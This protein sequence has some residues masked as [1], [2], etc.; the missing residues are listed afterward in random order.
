MSSRVVQQGRRAAK[1]K[2]RVRHPTARREPDGR[3]PR[4]PTGRRTTLFLVLFLAVAALSAIGV[5]MVLSA[6]AAASLSD[7]DD[8]WSLFRGQLIWVGV[9]AVALLVTMRIDYHRWRILAVPTL[10]LSLVLLVL[11]TVPGV[12]VTANGAS[13]WLGVGPFV[14]Q[15]SELAKLALV[16]F[17]ADLLARPTRPIDETGITLR[18][19]IAVTALLVLLLMLQPH[20]G[21]S[22]IIGVI[23]VAMLFLAG[24]PMLPLSGFA[25]AGSSLAAAVVLTSPWR[26]ARWLAFLDPW[27]DPLGHGYQPLQSLHAVTVGGLAGVG[28]GSS[29]AKWGFLPYAHTDFIF[30]VIAE[31]LGLFGAIAVVGLFATIGVAGFLTSLRA[32]DRFGML[33]AFGITTWILAQAV[34]NM[35]AVLALVPVLGVTLPFLSFGGSSLVV[36]M[37][38]F[39]L[40]LNVARQGR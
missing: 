36:T 6:S 20:L 23:A 31:E 11:V 8:A 7:T 14:F 5:V 4:R 19:V 17:V 32:P 13:R 22:I 24:T 18:P 3:G 25:V 29:R 27:A 28:L 2:A 35:G 34:L 40:L 30:A 12:G 15:P 33:L 16:L 37:A 10:V 21:A 26:R 39:G 9:G 38:A 1:A